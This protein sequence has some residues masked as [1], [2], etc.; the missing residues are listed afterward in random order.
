MTSKEALWPI[1]SKGFALFDIINSDDS[2]YSDQDIV[3][4]FERVAGDVASIMREVYG[5]DGHLDL[6]KEHESMSFG[7]F[8]HKIWRVIWKEVKHELHEI[9]KNMP[10]PDFHRMGHW[11]ENPMFEF[12]CPFS[13]HKMSF[14]KMPEFKC[15]FSGQPMS[16]AQFFPPMPM[17]GGQH[18]Q[19]KA[20][21]R[22][23]EMPAQFLPHFP[24]LADLHL[25]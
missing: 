25:F 4:E 5:F 9:V 19:A 1:F 14:P 20:L 10:H 18:H 2:C 16:F 7:H 8:I 24:N 22:P 11:G 15:P 21:G 13:G 6:T 3:R 23:D 12:T 17:F